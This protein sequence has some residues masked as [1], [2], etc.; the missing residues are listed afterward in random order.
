MNKPKILLFDIETAPNLA[1]VW[2]KYEQNVIDYKNE[3]YILCFCAKWLNEKNIT[4]SKLTDFNKRFNNDVQDDYGVVEKLWTLLNEADIVITH[5]GDEFDIKKANARFLYHGLPPPSLYKT[6]DT[7]KIAKKYFNFNSNK[8][9]D[10][11]RYLGLGRKVEHEGFNLWL[12]CM[13][14]DKKAWKIMIK[15]NKQDIVL[16]EKVYKK[17]LAWITNHPNLGLYTG[18]KYACPNCGSSHVNKRGYAFTKTQIYQKYQCQECF[19]WSQDVKSERD[20]I[21]PRLKN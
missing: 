1:Y 9:D 14:G 11:G 5:N 18:Q 3:W 10:L 20:I 6:I 19:A 2:G 8:L 15:Y 13:K 16:L 17:F 21:K 12:K 4:T 7:K